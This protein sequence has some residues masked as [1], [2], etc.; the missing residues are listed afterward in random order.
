MQGIG[1]IDL[2]TGK[3]FGTQNNPGFIQLT[4]SNAPLNPYSQTILDAYPITDTNQHFEYYSDQYVPLLRSKGFW[5]VNALDQSVAIDFVYSPSGKTVTSGGGISGQNG[6]T[7]SVAS[8]ASYYAGGNTTFSGSGETNQSGTLN[9]PTE[10]I[11]MVLQC[12]TAPT[13]G[14]VSITLLGSY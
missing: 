13:S 1:L 12:S 10:Q 8:G 2:S 5:I 3:P 14:S 7:I 6:P 9:D 11:L 4:G